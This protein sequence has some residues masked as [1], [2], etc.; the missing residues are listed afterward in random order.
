MELEKTTRLHETLYSGLDDIGDLKKRQPLLAHYTSVNVVESLLKQ[1][2]I[3]LSNPLNMNDHQE[4]AYGIK[5]GIG[6]VFTNDALRAAFTDERLHRQLL[7]FLQ[8]EWEAYGTLDV[9][10]LFVACFSEHEPSDLPDGKLSMW[11]GYGDFGNGAAIIFDS[12]EFLPIEESPFIFSEVWYAT[13]EDRAFRTREVMEKAAAF[14][15]SEGIQHNEIPTLAHVIFRRVVVGSV[16]T[17]HVG[18]DEEREWRLVYFPEYDV[19]ESFREAIDYHHGL[20]GLEPKMKLRMEQG[21]DEA[22]LGLNLEKAISS[23]VIG[24]RTSS[25]L[26]LHAAT[27]MLRKLN[28]EDLVSKLAYSTIP[29]RR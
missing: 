3:W 1:G 2:R 22:N 11:R 27:T 18:F 9:K 5:V 7:E 28:R 25:P 24:P 6:E 13:N 12:R 26:S 17:K 14:V 19:L 10:D 23:I 8:Q 16:F 21:G 4:V 15:S 20:H 29:F